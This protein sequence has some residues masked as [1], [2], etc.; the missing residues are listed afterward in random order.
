M[1]KLGELSGYLDAILLMLA[2]AYLSQKSTLRV[3][4]DC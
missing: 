4:L 3:T 2:P 1:H